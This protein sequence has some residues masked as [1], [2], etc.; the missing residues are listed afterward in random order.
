VA[1]TTK[2]TKEVDM[3]SKEVHSSDTK[4]EEEIKSFV[5]PSVASKTKEDAVE[6]TEAASNTK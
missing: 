5:E 2:E 3:E 4:V 6:S 1:P